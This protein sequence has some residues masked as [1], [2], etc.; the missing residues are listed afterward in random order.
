M[1]VENVK[2]FSN[3]DVNTKTKPDKINI[4]SDIHQE[5]EDE[6]Q[7]LNNTPASELSYDDY[8]R[9]VKY[10]RMIRGLTRNTKLH[11]AFN[12]KATYFQAGWLADPSILTD[13]MMISTS[14]KK[15]DS[16]SEIY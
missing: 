15:R 2:S 8:W 1:E 10:S 14:W 13:N 16:D 4:D 11:E 6:Y 5:V 3:S 9:S 12:Q 7:S